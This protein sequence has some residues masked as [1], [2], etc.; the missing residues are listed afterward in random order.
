MIEIQDNDREVEY[1]NTIYLIKFKGGNLN[2]KKW[3]ILIGVLLLFSITFAN[4]D[5]GLGGRSPKVPTNI[6]NIIF[7]QN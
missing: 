4:K 7:E 6:S 3:L 1:T 2:E 5:I